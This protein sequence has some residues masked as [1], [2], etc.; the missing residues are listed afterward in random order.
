MEPR[1]GAIVPLGTAITGPCEPARPPS[2]DGLV[3]RTHRW[4]AFERSDQPRPFESGNPLDLPTY[5]WNEAIMPRGKYEGAPCRAFNKPVTIGLTPAFRVWELG[6]WW[7]YPI[8][9]QSEWQYDDQQSFDWVLTAVTHKVLGANR[10]TVYSP[11]HFVAQEVQGRALVGRPGRRPE[12]VKQ[13]TPIKAGDTLTVQGEGSQ[14]FGRVRVTNPEA[15]FSLGFGPGEYQFSDPRKCLQYIEEGREAAAM[16]KEPIKPRVKKGV[17]DQAFDELNSI[18]KAGK[19][20]Y[21]DGIFSRLRRASAP[22]FRGGGPPQ[23]RFKVVRRKGRTKSCAI[24]GGLRVYTTNK[25]VPKRKREL[26]LK[27]GQCAVTKDG[28]APRRVRR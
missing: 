3:N 5:G 7:A 28:R 18:I 21:N 26:R 10:F 1:N 8:V 22:A 9:T 14:R 17:V 12:V 25:R 11:C 4:T 15:G 24:R 2:G 16:P 20:L 27:Q 23:G 6:R 19:D 13:G